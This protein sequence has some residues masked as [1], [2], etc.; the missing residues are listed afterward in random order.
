MAL[1]QPC[2]VALCAVFTLGI[3]QVELAAQSNTISGTVFVDENF[4]GAKAVS[5]DGQGGALIK[6]YWDDNQNG[7]LDAGDFVIDSTLSNPNGTYD[8]SLTYGSVTVSNIIM[9]STDDAEQNGSS[10]ELSST[11]LD[12]ASRIIGLRYRNVG[13]KQGATISSAYITFEADGDLTSTTTV[14][15]R[16]HDTDNS[17]TF[18]SSNND[19]STRTT[20]SASATWNN[21]PSWTEKQFYNSVSLVS[22]IQEIVDRPGWAAGNALAI[23]IENG[24]GQR[25]AET[26]DGDPSQAARLYVTYSPG[27]ATDYFIVEIDGASMDGASSSYSTATSY[28]VSFTGAGQTSTGNDFGF[29]G[30][31]P[32]CFAVAD[33]QDDLYITNRFTGATARVGALGATGVEAIALNEGRDT[34]WAVDED[35]FGTIDMTTG[36][37]IGYGNSLGNADGAAG[38][39]DLD[40][41]DGL[42]FDPV[43]DELWGAHREDGQ[44][45]YIFKISR[46]TG[47]F[48]AD[49]FGSGVD[50]LQLS[51]SGI[52][53]D[54]DD[55]A[56]NPDNGVL[57]AV[58]NSDGG[59]TQLITINTSTGVGTV[60]ASLGTD[61]IE[62][63][64][65][66]N[67]GYFYATSGNDAYGTTDDVFWRINISTGVL[68]ELGRF[69]SGEDFEGCDC[70]TA[71][72][73]QI[74]PVELLNFSASWGDNQVDLAWT[75]ASETNN[76]RFEVE[77]A[78]SPGLTETILIVPGAGNSNRV[79]S[80]KAHDEEPLNGTSY[81][82]LKQVDINDSYA[83]SSW[84]K[85][86]SPKAS[87][88][89]NVFP[90]PVVE[91]KVLVNLTGA[92][93]DRF[94][95]IKIT[96]VRGV[97][98]EAAIKIR[99]LLNGKQFEIGTLNL[100]PGIYL[101]SIST[102]SDFLTRSFIIR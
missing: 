34:L 57:Y 67:D 58:N 8:F 22:I 54:L 70:L 50:Y 27:G 86:V 69:Y 94:K 11:D 4:N 35:E 33:E 25:E 65:F 12:I 41:V 47:T 82:R 93:V 63:Q 32:M 60:V 81:Y 20:T 43:N 24:S 59:L 3:P 16:G 21:I 71:N 14:T 29:T 75:T 13:I 77:R 28:D 90:N 31:S 1:F 99:D 30:P 55:L 51:G 64:G 87:G 23:I 18:T 7:L 62:G 15:V 46:T 95:D 48:V 68:T 91:D 38:T 19:I 96:D 10:M 5:E 61:D 79:L 72:E 44:F 80:Y 40:D 89:I 6:L 76:D 9:E 52:Y 17:S 36:T 85:V 49:A 92:W 84:V 83:Y 100:E 56:F 2:L 53:N 97:T 26:F 73:F 101:I 39:V 45:D 37:F 74:L 102:D 66:S 42:S 78:Y 88:T 98:R